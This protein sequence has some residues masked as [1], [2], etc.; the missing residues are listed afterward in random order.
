MN[1]PFRINHYRLILG[2][3]FTLFPLLSHAGMVGEVIIKRGMVDDDIY[4]AGAQVDLYATVN[5]DVVVAGGQ[6]NLEGNIKADVTAA[7]GAISLRGSV[8]DDA[9]LAGGEVRVSAQIGDDLVAAAGRVHL[10]PVANIAGRAWLSGGDIRVDGQVAEELR[11]A[12]GR[13][14]I[15]GTIN[16]NVELWAEQIII[17]ETA[18]IAGSLHYK[19]AHQADI[20][21]GARIDGEVVHTPVE[22]QMK[23]VIASIIIASLVILF[24]LIVTAV[25]IFLLFPDYSQRVSQSLRDQP[26]QSL[27]IGLAV[28]AGAPLLMVILFSTVLGTWLALIVLAMYLVILLLGYFAGALS[29][30]NA[31]LALLRKTEVSKALR[32]TALAVAIIVL[33]VINLLPLLGSLFNWLV[34]LAGTGAL[35][36]QLYLAYRA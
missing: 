33:A 35:S 22:I 19:S 8:A 9:R 18:V 27:A 13:V 31:G 25:L 5:G 21:T 28:L 36:R 34:L 10:S 4:L 20:A 3:V 17:E 2:F 32:A 29:V 14:V 7:G 24:S 16:G 12:G 1:A 26:W 6:L 15:S 23:P 11:A 30:G